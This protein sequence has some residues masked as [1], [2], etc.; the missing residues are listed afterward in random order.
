MDSNK[1]RK[2]ERET[3]RVGNQVGNF[4]TRHPLWA[5]VIALA[6]VVGL[7]VGAVAVAGLAR[8]ASVTLPAA[9]FDCPSGVLA[10]AGTT[11]TC[12]QSVA[13]TPTPPTTGFENC[14]S[15]TFTRKPGTGTYTAGSPII[16]AGDQMASL[17]IVVPLVGMSTAKKT[18]Q[19]AYYTQGGGWTYSVSERACDLAPANAVQTITSAGAVNP[20]Q[21]L[22]GYTSTGVH[23]IYYKGGANLLAGKTYYFNV[24][25]DPGGASLIGSLPAL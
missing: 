13:P 10:Q 15:G 22:A 3:E 20:Y 23:T 5:G 21:K 9:T 18:S 12:T 11:Y 17:A 14:P 8:A 7:V 24:K 1:L 4:A 25:A 2:V 19:W 6:I 16:L